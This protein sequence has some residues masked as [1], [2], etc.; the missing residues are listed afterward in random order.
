MQNDLM[1]G[2]PSELES[3]LG[4]VVRMGREAGLPTPV[5]EFLYAILLPMEMKARQDYKN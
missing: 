3:Q 5:N 2:R 1:N 4:T